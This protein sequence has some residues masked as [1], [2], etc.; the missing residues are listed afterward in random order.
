MT[1]CLCC[2]TPFED[3]QCQKICKSCSESWVCNECLPEYRKHWNKKCCICKEGIGV[4]VE[5]DRAQRIETITEKVMV[6]LT[7]FLAF[8]SPIVC[9][10]LWIEYPMGDSDT[11]EFVLIRGLPYEFVYSYTIMYLRSKFPNASIVIVV[12]LWLTMGHCLYI[13][14]SLS[15]GTYGNVFMYYGMVLCGLIFIAVIAA[16]A[17]GCIELFR[18]IFM[19]SSQSILPI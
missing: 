4:V 19:R 3:S 15:S 17:M 18:K 14:V 8:I 7:A 1:T 9:C 5:S 2:L 11:A 16:L 13:G 6:F 12:N 10:Y